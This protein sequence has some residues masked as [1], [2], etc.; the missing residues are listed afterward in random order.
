MHNDPDRIW[1]VVDYTEIVVKT[2]AFIIQELYGN[3]RLEAVSPQ[4][5]AFSGELHLV[6]MLGN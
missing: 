6:P 3:F 4:T 2:S 5:I 1:L